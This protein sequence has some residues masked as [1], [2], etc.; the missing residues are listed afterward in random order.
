MRLFIIAIA[1]TMG[2]APALAAPQVRG[3]FSGSYFFAYATNGENRPYSCNFSY[4]FQYSDF[5]EIKTRQINGNF[6]VPAN[7]N[8]MEVIKT[9]GSWV[10][11]QLTNF[12]YQCT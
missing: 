4:S 11:P 9:T 7:A 3:A 1:T 10:N 8:N 5:G 12:S 6:G 2:V